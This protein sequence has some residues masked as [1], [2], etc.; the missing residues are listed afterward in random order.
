MFQSTIALIALVFGV[1]SQM[2]VG[3]S[4][5]GFWFGLT[6]YLTTNGFTAADY[7]YSLLLPNDCTGD[8]I[9]FVNTL[10]TGPSNTS[11][12]TVFDTTLLVPE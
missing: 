6:N 10:M 5:S 11:Q 2:A 3:Q 9:S 12:G 4:I 7:F 1:I 8:C